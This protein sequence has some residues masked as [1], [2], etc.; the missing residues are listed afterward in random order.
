MTAS[1][2]YRIA[3]DGAAE[4]RPLDI[5]N[6]DRDGCALLWLHVDGNDPDC[7]RWLADESGLPAPV[8]EALTAVE[9]RPRAVQLAD[10]V[11]LNL[12]GVNTAPD[13]D[14]E[15]LV[16]VRLW[17]QAGRVISVNFRPLLAIDDL[18]AQVEAGRARDPGDLIVRLAD[19]MTARLDTVIAD[20][21][22]TADTLEADVIDGRVEDLRARIGRVRRAAIEL[23][24]YISPQRDALSGLLLGRFD[25]LHEDD[26]IQIGEA[27]NRVIRMVEE[28]DSVRER[29]AVLTEQL[30]DI[31]AE[32]MNERALI[33][34]VASAV[35]LPLT[36]VTGL[37]GMNVEGIPFAQERWAFAG[38]LASCLALGVGLWI[39]LRKREGV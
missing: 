29:T 32:A 14:P 15:D 39:W 23:R 24:R 5:A 16:S 37:L 38:V 36:F 30:A 20:L 12:R 19:V 2:V 9:T 22:D 27:I 7:R 6:C 26:R 8:V 28:L 13:A 18:V 1:F 10:G 21:G 4:R 17:A 33:L 35:F 34:A 25:W 31:R 3:A 11:L